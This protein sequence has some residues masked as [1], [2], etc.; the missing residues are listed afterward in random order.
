MNGSMTKGSPVVLIL[1][2][3]LPLLLGN[4]LQQAYNMIDSAIVGQILGVG[5]LSSV[6]ATSSVQ[7][8]VLGFCIGICAGFGVP[9]AKYFGAQHFRRLRIC[10]THAF[11]LTAAFAVVLTLGTAF[12]CHGILRLMSIP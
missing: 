6:G 4:L 1:R 10:V 2:F 11:M 7:F 5:A 12:F 8:L 9:V 3:S